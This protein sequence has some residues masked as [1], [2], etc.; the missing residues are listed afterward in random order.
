MTTE[1]PANAARDIKIRVIDLRRTSRIPHLR[2]P[3]KPLS[4]FRSS[5]LI[6]PRTRRSDAEHRRAPPSAAAES[7]DRVNYRLPMKKL[8]R[9]REKRAGYTA[10]SGRGIRYGIANH[11]NTVP[12]NSCDGRIAHFYSYAPVEITI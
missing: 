1:C 9:A 4:V 2:P 3:S 5:A 12:R 11:F 8:T 6:T 10:S 7:R